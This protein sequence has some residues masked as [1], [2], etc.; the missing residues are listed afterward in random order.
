MHRVSIVSAALDEQYAMLA[1]AVAWL[2]SDDAS[3]VNGAV[4][5]VDGGVTTVDDGTLAFGRAG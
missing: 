3:Y 4:L 5:P 1:G 2:L